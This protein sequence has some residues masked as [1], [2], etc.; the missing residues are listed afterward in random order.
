MTKYNLLRMTQLILSAMDSDEVNSISDTTESLQVVDVIE[1]TYND[2]VSTLDFPDHWDFFELESS[3]D[4]TRPTLMTLPSNIGKV[5]WIKY[6][7]SEPGSTK[8]E[9]RDVYP[10]ERERF[11][12]RSN[13]LDSADANTYRYDLLVGTGTFDIR[14][15]NDAWPTYYTT[16]ND[17]TLIFDNFK[18]DSGQT[19][20]GNRTYCYGMRIPVFIREDT[21]VPELT[22]RQF[23]LLF[24]EAKSQAFMDL[25]QVQNAKSE[26]R[27][28]RG[29]VQAHRKAPQTGRVGEKYWDYT[30][31]FGRRGRSGGVIRRNRG[32]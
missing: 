32:N 30:Y 9:F 6:D 7:M 28:R 17:K 19:L 22:P 21:F 27:A 24:N 15:K 29:W 4:I 14:G 20:M 10:L 26:Q 2:L 16:N 25:K 18:L 12:D 11:L 5:E 1:T 31:D 8:R 23:T 3:G 13:S